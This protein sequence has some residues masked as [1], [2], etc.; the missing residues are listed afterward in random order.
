MRIV[1]FAENDSGIFGTL[2]H[3]N[4]P[5]CVTLERNWVGNKRNISCIP[6]GTY[7]YKKRKSSSKNKQTNYDVFEILDVMDRDN[8]LIHIGNYKEDSQGCILVGSYFTEGM[9][10]RSA[11]AMEKL[12]QTIPNEGIIEIVNNY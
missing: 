11:D 6:F 1:R 7:R 9:I 8:I 5:V 2:T 3:D 12:L 4:N 10:C